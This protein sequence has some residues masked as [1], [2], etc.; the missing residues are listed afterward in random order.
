M[1]RIRN[2]PRCP[3]TPTQEKGTKKATR[4]GRKVRGV[5]NNIAGIVRHGEEV[6]TIE[7]K[8]GRDAGESSDQ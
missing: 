3:K 5:N 6:G 8:A 1:R 7:T 2:G 4:K